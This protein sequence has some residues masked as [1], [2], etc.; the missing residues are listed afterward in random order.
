MAGHNETGLC[1]YLPKPERKHTVLHIPGS[2]TLFVGPSACMRRHAIREEEYGNRDDVS[3]LYISEADVISGKY[4]Q[5][6]ADSIDDLINILRP[7]PYIFFIATFCIDDFLGTDEEALLDNL[8]ARHPDR[9]FSA[10]HIDPVSLEDKKNQGMKKKVNMFSFIKEGQEKDRGVNFIG[11]F[12]P[13]P[14]ECEFLS[15]LESWGAGPVRELFACKTYEEYQDMGKSRLNLALR[16]LESHSCEYMKSRLGI[17][18]YSFPTSYDARRIARG[19]ADIAGLLGAKC[20]DLEKEISECEEDAR[21]TAKLL[22][23][24]PVA[25]DSGAF[26]NPF[27]GA[28]ALLG[29]GFNVKYIFKPDHPM[30]E[31][32]EAEGTVREK[33]P[34]TV[35]SYVKSSKYLYESAEDEDCMAIGSDCARLLK[36]KHFVNIWHDEGY[37]GFYGIRRLMGDIRAAAQKETDWSSMPDLNIKR[38][39]R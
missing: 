16:S 18:Y 2:H 21:Y 19:Y 1:Y 10:E 37:F 12:V 22:N 38:K 35:I 20:E 29:Y 25:V 7:V 13:L 34:D 15:L 30:R 9:Q 28:L 5:L 32:K 26:M 36:A 17:P 3:F 24:M 33:Y 23:G 6:I 39:E 8:R 31:E 14:A 4:E 27:A 11:T